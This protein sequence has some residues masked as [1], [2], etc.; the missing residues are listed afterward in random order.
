MPRICVQQNVFKAQKVTIITKSVQLFYD[1]WWFSWNRDASTL[2]A[3]VTQGLRTLNADED[4][5]FVRGARCPLSH[6]VL[7]RG[8]S[9]HTF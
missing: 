9:R 3:A 2:V 5:H 6:I 1:P 8:D 4:E 7:A